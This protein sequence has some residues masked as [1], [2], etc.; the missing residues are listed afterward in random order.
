MKVAWNQNWRW[1]VERGKYLSILYYP[2]YAF[3]E[4]NAV[5]PIASCEVNG[6]PNTRD[7]IHRLV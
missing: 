7:K 3:A 1:G 5:A 6:R 4:A 2:G